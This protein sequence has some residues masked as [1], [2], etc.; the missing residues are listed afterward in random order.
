MVEPE[1][2]VDEEKP[3]TYSTRLVAVME[4]D[5]EVLWVMTT[6]PFTT[7]KVGVFVRERAV[8]AVFIAVKRVEIEE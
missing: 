1:P 7:E 3:N 8:K 2:V 6:L 4:Y 5:A